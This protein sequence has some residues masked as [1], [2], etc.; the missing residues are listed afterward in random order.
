M[1]SYQHVA[2]GNG[3]CNDADRG[4]LA[5]HEGRLLCAQ[6]QNEPAAFGGDV[7]WLE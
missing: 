7:N 4:T 5:W 1:K 3:G 2:E 6:L